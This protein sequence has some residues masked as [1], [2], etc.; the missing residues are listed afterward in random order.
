MVLPSPG[1]YRT[2]W[3]WAFNP[4][5]GPFTSPLDDCFGEALDSP[6]GHED[7]LDG[8]DQFILVQMWPNAAA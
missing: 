2:R 3:Q 8:A 6:G 4:D 5:A 7:A 1:T